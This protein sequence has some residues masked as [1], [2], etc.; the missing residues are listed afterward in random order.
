MV[1]CRDAIRTGAACSDAS[2]RRTPPSCRVLLARVT[3]V[4]VLIAL[5]VLKHLSVIGR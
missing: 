5:A 3:V 2:P 4:I 1:S